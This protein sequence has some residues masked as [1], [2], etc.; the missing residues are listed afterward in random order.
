MRK[1]ENMRSQAEDCL[2]QIVG[3]TVQGANVADIQAAA[4]TAGVGARWNGA[5]AAHGSS[6]GV[7]AG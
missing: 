2:L 6:G 5:S 3:L 1:V 4:E 7:G